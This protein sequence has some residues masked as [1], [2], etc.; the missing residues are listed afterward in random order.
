MADNRFP[1]VGVDAR[2]PSPGVDVRFPAPGQDLEHL[3]DGTDTRF[4]GSTYGGATGSPPVISVAPAVTGDAVRGSTLS[5]TTGTWAQSPGGGA[6][7]YAYQW[8]RDGA[9]IGGATSSTYATT[10]SDVGTAVGCKVTATDVYG[11]SSPATATGAVTVLSFSGAVAAMLAGTDGFAIPFRAADQLKQDAAGTIVVTAGADP[12]GRVNTLYGLA[13]NNFSTTADGFRAAWSGSASAVADGADDWMGSSASVLAL[14]PGKPALYICG[15]AKFN[16]L[17]ARSSLY[18][19]GWGN[20]ALLRLDVLD[21]GLVKAEVRRESGDANTIVD[22]ATGAVSLGAAF[23]HETI[24][25]FAG[26]GAI[27]TYINGTLAGSG[28]LPET[29]APCSL[30]SGLSRAYLFRSN[31]NTALYS[32]ANW[33]DA[34]VAFKVPSAGERTIC[35]AWVEEVPL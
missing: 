21:T 1:S 32:N 35:R 7:S 16:A 23:T 3:P 15:R 9:N 19:L 20:T 24:I 11:A 13:A 33:G 27:S 14:F 34:V 5:C 25:D 2:F 8:T 17:P 12:V 26:T 22:S 31:S 30:E 10:G 18:G 29:P 6:L 4:Q 28:T